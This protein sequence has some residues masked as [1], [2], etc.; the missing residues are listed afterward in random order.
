MQYLNIETDIQQD[1]IPA[2]ADPKG[3]AADAA[4]LPDS[5]VQRNYGGG[6]EGRSCAGAHCTVHARANSMT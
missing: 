6:C 5:A 2:K 1:L 4:Q 3:A